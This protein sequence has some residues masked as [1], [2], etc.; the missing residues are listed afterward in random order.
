ML[1]L[2]AHNHGAIIDLLQARYYQPYVRLIFIR[3]TYLSY[4]DRHDQSYFAL[5]GQVC[6]KLNPRGRSKHHPLWPI[7]R[8]L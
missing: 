2:L 7:N 6:H 8:E 5:T 4:R 1:Y 3:D